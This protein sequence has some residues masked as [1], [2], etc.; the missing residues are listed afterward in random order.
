MTNPHGDPNPLRSVPHPALMG[1]FNLE[2]DPDDL[3][4]DDLDDE[5]EEDEAFGGADEDADEDDE[6]LD[7]EEEEDEDETWQVAHSGRIPLKA[8][9]GLTSGADLLDWRRFSQ[10]R[11]GWETTRPMRVPTAWLDVPQSLVNGRV[12]WDAPTDSERRASA[13]QPGLSRGF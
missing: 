4:D 1:R 2:D 12:P 5:D 6:D 8:G 9:P 13:C 3:D 11:L 10:L 7:E